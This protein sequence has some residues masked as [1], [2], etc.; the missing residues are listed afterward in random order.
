MRSIHKQKGQKNAN[1]SWSFLKQRGR[2]SIQVKKVPQG[3]N[4]DLKNEI[5]VISHNTSLNTLLRP[6][7]PLTK[8]PW[9]TSVMRVQKAPSG[10]KKG[11]GI[12][13]APQR[14]ESI[15]WGKTPSKN[16]HHL[17]AGR[18]VGAVSVLK[19]KTQE[20][21][22]S[23]DCSHDATGSTPVH[24]HYYSRSVDPC[25]RWAPAP[26]TAGNFRTQKR[27]VS[28]NF[29]KFDMSTSS[30]KTFPLY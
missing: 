1:S 17:R 9:T 13:I 27:E 7:A 2:E 10:H 6:S 16:H 4:W 11:D 14:I 3:T 19:K 15:A 30:A 12:P 22:T 21:L 26:H 18:A 28:H 24:K 8:T 5:L 20:C 23:W 25:Q 29:P